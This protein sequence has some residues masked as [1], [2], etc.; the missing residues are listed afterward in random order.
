MISFNKKKPQS[1]QWVILGL[2]LVTVGVVLA[3][4]IYKDHER[5]GERE[6]E[7]LLTQARIVEENLAWNLNAVSKTLITLQRDPSILTFHTSYNQR[8]SDLADAM[9]GIRTIFVMDAEG[10]IRTSSRPEL[11]GKNFKERDYFQTPRQSRS[12]DMLYVSPPFK[13]VLGNYVINLSRAIHNSRGEFAGIVSAALDPVYFKT[14]L[15]SVRYE[16]DMWTSITHGD[17]TLF[18]IV[19]DRTGTAGKN[20]LQPGTFVSRHRDSGKSSTVGS[21]IVYATNELRMIALQTI[22]PESLEMDRSLI[23]MATRDLEAVYSTWRK[24][25]ILHGTLFALFA[26]ISSLAL[27]L[28]QRRQREVELQR[29][30][31]GKELKLKQQALEKSE[32]FMRMLTDIIPGMVGYWT[33]ELRCGFANIAYLEWFGKT[34]EQMRG[35]HIRELLGEELFGK[36][37]Q[38]I[39]AALRGERQRFE[40]TL[41]KVDGSTSYVWAHYIPDCDNDQVKG[42]FVLVSDITELKQT[43]FQLENINKKL[44]KRTA[45]AEAASNSKSE[46]LANMSHEIRTPMNAILGLTRLVLETELAPRQKNFLQKVYSSSEALMGILNGILD[47]SKMEAGC[48]EIECLPMNLQQI[49]NDTAELFRAL[50]EEKGLNILINIDPDVPEVVSGDPLRLSQVLN[51]LVGNAVKFTETGEIH[52]KVESSKAD[53]DN[54]TLFF[55]VRDTGIGIGKDQSDRLFQAFTQA[56]GTITRKYGGTGLGLA[57]CRNLVKLMGGDIQVSS[58]EGEGSTFTFLIQVKIMPPGTMISDRLNKSPGLKL[59]SLMAFSA[60]CQAASDLDGL[61]IL[62]VEDNRINQEVAAELL[63]LR[64]ATVTLAGNGAE[65]LDLVRR[66]SFDAVLMD[67]QMPIMD[68]LE[69]TINIREIYETD[70]LP[71]IAMTSAVMQDDRERCKAAGMVDFIAKP[72]NP[73]ELVIVLRKYLKLKTPVQCSECENIG[74]A[75]GFPE[76]SAIDIA[77]ALQRVNGNSQLLHSLLLRFSED[78]GGA[79]AQLKLLLSEGKVGQALHLVHAIKGVAA[80]LGA[81]KLAESAAVLEQELKSGVGTSTLPDFERKCTAAISAIIVFLHGNTETSSR[82]DPV[83][84]LDL[85]KTGDLL[86][87]L[88][89]YL[90]E[91]ELVPDDLVQKV[92]VLAQSRQSNETASLFK[93]LLRQLDHFDHGGAL[94]TVQRFNDTCGFNQ[95]LDAS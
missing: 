65:A 74:E 93:I 35:I 57:I 62:L 79:P 17:G 16:E 55:T 95:A 60:T 67:M 94:E 33:N 28:F 18:L 83:P 46:F 36:N 84:V 64:G 63:R 72:I 66:S 76:N 11:V 37:E 92:Y 10:A 21:G 25:A 27:F 47:Y 44:T 77:S 29:S 23:V 87:E 61:R 6:E 32:R 91:Q 68:G 51:N 53:D 58:V 31:A 30:E 22:Q 86:A 41:I 9:P 81:K 73:D 39:N 71:I 5:T 56:D 80:T 12:Q 49:I 42:F 45:E 90:H 20:L 43:Q 8:F 70:K 34:P 1:L 88:S 14:L 54:L 75:G 19:P 82:N 24:D 2:L 26:G 78:H 40:R 85:E 4:Q 13:T 89:T 52:I 69:A 50:I 59:H 3:A 48:L 15:S 7:R 38:F